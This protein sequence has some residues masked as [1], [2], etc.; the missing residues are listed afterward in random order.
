MRHERPIDQL[1]TRFDDIARV[2]A[3]SFSWR[4]E[5]LDLQPTF[6]LNHNRTLAAFL[7]GKNLDHTIDLGQNR[8]IF[9]LSSF[10]NLG[11]SRQTTRN[12]RDARRFTR[13][14]RHGRTGRDHLAFFDHDV[15]SF[16]QVVHIQWLAI[17]A[18][19]NDLRM[20]VAF[21]V[22]NRTANCTTGLFL[23]GHGLAINDIF[24]PDLTGDLRH[25]WNRVRVPGTDNLTGFDFVTFSNFQSRTLRDLV[26]LK[27][28]TTSIQNRNFTISIQND[29][30][31]F[32]ISNVTHTSNAYRS[33]FFSR[34]LVVFGNRI[35]HTTNV[36]CTHRQLS[37]RL[38]NRLSRDDSNR[39]SFFN[40]VTGRHVH[41][42][43][44]TTNAQRS[45]TSHRA[46]DL[47]F[48]QSHL[49]NLRGDL[50]ID[51]LVLTN[52]DLIRHWINNI[53][54][55]Y[56]TVNRCRQANLNLLAAINH[57]FGDTAGRPAILHRD[58]NVLCNVGQLTRQVTRVSG[59]ECSIRQTFTSTV[60]RREI[61]E[62]RQAF[63]EIRLN[64]SFDNF[65]RRLGHQA[66]HTR[67]LTN[68]FD[69]T[70]STRI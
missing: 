14:F 53:L 9:R 8:R 40:H 41:S 23:G 33:G 66:S 37:T 70:T 59:L 29:G 2:H 63:T 68:L 28:A 31:A 52:D 34:L 45:L 58:H 43:A 13:R 42:V 1:L 62:N 17:F 50:R 57:T 24:E 39:H 54:P 48:L 44:Q 12:V 21:E 16:R 38:T 65:T 3:E 25:D 32:I 5:V 55:R 49:F 35:S 10:E 69:T 61:L 64:R 18:L 4:H 26:I 60:R 15:G 56:P 47:D 22:D 51:H 20:H 7:F 30:V 11:D 36:E 6:A 46:T 19:N 67:Q 27:L